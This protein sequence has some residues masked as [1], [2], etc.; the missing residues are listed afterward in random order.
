MKRFTR[1]GL[2]LIVTMLL[3]LLG[4]FSWLS[5]MQASN[6]VNPAQTVPNVTPTD[7]GII[8]YDNIEF[9][10]S[11]GLTLRG[12]Y[13]PPEREDGATMI[14]V[15]GQASQLF[16]IFAEIRFF[17]EEGYGVLAFD[18]RGHG[19]SDDAPNTMGITEVYDVQSAYEYLLTRDET[20]PERIGIFGESMGAATTI[21]AAEQLP[22]LRIV[23]VDSAYTSIRET[24]VTGIPLVVGIPPLFFPDLI[25]A[26]SSFQSGVD[27]YDANPL[28]AIPNVTQPIFFMH[29]TA[30]SQ[31][32]Y[33]H[34]EIL[35]EATNSPKELYILEG[36]GHVSGFDVD[37]EAFEAQITPFL[38]QYF[39]NE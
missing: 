31:V 34:S 35:Y 19:R 23:I 9:V 30:D 39:V 4:A 3:G 20:N 5:W 8:T 2:F 15:H 36:V 37:P 22:E 21:L 16:G 26:M 18:L 12:Y 29:G 25:V 1:L 13:F 10:T 28:E 6:F 38:E 7:L 17:V 27:Y 24:L 32:P 33:Q 14:M 11:D